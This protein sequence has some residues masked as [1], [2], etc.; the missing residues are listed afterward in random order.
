M[1]DPK[2]LDELG[3]Q[4]HCL[5]CEA[6]RSEIFC[7]RCGQRHVEGRLSVRS[8]LREL[9]S[10]LFS[11]DRGFFFTMLQLWRSPGRVAHH[12][13]H[14][15]RKRFTTPLAVFIV[16]TSMQLVSLSLQSDNLRSA[17]VES[18]ETAQARG[19]TSMEK[20]E[21]MF[22][23]EYEAKL[24]DLYIATMSQGY[25]YASFFFFCIPLALALSLLHRGKAPY[26]LGENLVF[27]VFVVSQLL[28]ST[29]IF[30]QITLP[31]G[32]GIQFAVN[33]VLYFGYTLLS[34]RDFYPVGFGS[35]LRTL[36]AFFLAVLVFFVSLIGIF[37]VTVAVQVILTRA[38]A[39]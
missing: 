3:K 30:S 33:M 25:T 38:S 11:L 34:H 39:G 6:P 19:D 1:D 18:F 24:A 14:G 37:A 5:N 35:L 26:Q 7:Q 15:R 29:A 4:D 20:L 22:G 27:A 9:P 10:R 23:A 2:L 13:V 16:A 36:V 17:V 8:M 12:Y 31:A 21:E 32:S 28:I